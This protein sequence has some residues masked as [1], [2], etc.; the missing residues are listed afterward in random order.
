VGRSQTAREVVLP[1]LPARVADTITGARE[2]LV[3]PGPQYW[4][5][6]V[7]MTATVAF[8]AWGKA[9]GRVRGHMIVRSGGRPHVAGVD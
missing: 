8:W 1:E 9:N 6:G 3:G 4:D 7:P 5:R 2:S